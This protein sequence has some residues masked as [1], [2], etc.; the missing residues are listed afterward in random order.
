MPLQPILPSPIMPTDLERAFIDD[1]PVGLWPDNQNSNFGLRRKILCD[2]LTDIA[3][4]LQTLLNERLIATSTQFL[5]QWEEEMGVPINPPNRTVA[6]RRSTIESRLKRGAFTRTLRS[7]IVESYINAV[8]GG[9]PLIL[10]PG[11]AS[12]GTGVPL[13]TGLVGPASNY[14]KIRE[15]DPSKNLLPNSNFEVNTSGW[16]TDGTYSAITITTA[17]QR[18][19]THSLQATAATVNPYIHYAAGIP[20]G[21]GFPYTVSGWI[22]TST[23]G[24]LAVIQLQWRNSSGATISQPISAAILIPTSTWVRVSMTATSPAGT[25][26]LDPIFQISGASVGN[27]IYYDALQVEAGSTL[28]DYSD[29]QGSPFY[30]EVRI[31]NTLTIDLIN[32]RNDLLRLTPAGITFDVNSVALP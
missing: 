6:Q 5:S 16:A 1:S 22:F 2:T 31:L 11:G 8:L 23:P 32:L 19:G 4:Q 21:S 14:Y 27:N 28:T 25:V 24:L 18:Y 7:T 30:Y 13:G 10:G 3:N 17:Q 12:L 9:T 26:A 20:V 15:N 29:A